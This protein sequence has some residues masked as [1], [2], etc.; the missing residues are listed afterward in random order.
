MSSTVSTKMIIPKTIT[1]GYQKRED[2]YTKQLAYVIYTDAK[3]V[4]RKENSWNSWRDKKITPNTYDNVPT[5]GFVLNRKVGGYRSDWNHR[6]TYVRVFDPRGF[7]F[8]ISVP[9]LLYILQETSAIKGKGLDGE[10]V[11]SWDGKDVVL[12]PVTSSEYTACASFTKLQSQKVTKKD[13]VEGH[14]YQMKDLTNVLYLGRLD[15]CEKE[16]TYTRNEKGEYKTKYTYKPIGLHHVFLNLDKQTNGD[17][18]GTTPYI[19]EKGFTRIAAKTSTEESPLYGDAYDKFKRSR[20]Y[21]KVIDVKVEEVDISENDIESG[22]RF[23]V[24]INEKLH[25]IYIKRRYNPYSYHTYSGTFDVYVGQEI[26]PKLSSSGHLDLPKRLDVISQE[27][28]LTKSDILKKKF[29]NLYLVTETG[30]KYQ[31]QGSYYNY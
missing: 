28:S 27:S 15:Y 5:S 22:C 26:E 21:G 1:V 12:L 3:G 8:E 4:L 24:K 16:H 23:I 19:I 18:E 17:D 29:C 30:R 2:T 20:Y 25:P 9:N 7:E 14:T 11:Y 31:L 10:F 6:A 13:M